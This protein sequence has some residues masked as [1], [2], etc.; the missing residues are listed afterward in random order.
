MIRFPSLFTVYVSCK[1]HTKTQMFVKFR[2]Q[3]V[4]M[5]RWSDLSSVRTLYN[6]CGG[7]P[8]SFTTTFDDK[9]AIVGERYRSTWLDFANRSIARFQFDNF[10]LVSHL[11][12]R[13]CD[14][15]IP[16]RSYHLQL[17]FSQQIVSYTGTR[18]SDECEHHKS[19]EDLTNEL[20]G[21]LLR[22]VPNGTLVAISNASA[23]FI[24]RCE[25]SE[26]Q[27]NWSDAT[28]CI[29]FRSDRWCCH[30]ERKLARKPNVWHLFARLM[31]FDLSALA[32]NLA[33]NETRPHRPIVSA[34]ICN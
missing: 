31:L 26:S 16:R 3:R 13:K 27:F 2:H 32:M 22:L 20:H 10:N 17:L 28:Q 6:L 21:V 25:L 8:A 15:W 5:K 24:H 4:K 18:I 23:V 12:K 34:S 33:G 19:D 30:H 7:K 11:W 29:P 14:W 9:L 1:W